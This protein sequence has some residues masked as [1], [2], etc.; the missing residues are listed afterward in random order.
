MIRRMGG[1][2]RNYELPVLNSGDK[3]AVTNLEKA[4]VLAQTFR[5]G[6]VTWG[7]FNQI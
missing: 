3:V 5:K 7:I 1:V 4:E 2:R 6:H